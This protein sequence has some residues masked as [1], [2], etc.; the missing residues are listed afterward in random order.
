[1]QQANKRKHANMGQTDKQPTKHMQCVANHSTHQYSCRRIHTNL[2]FRRILIEYGYWLLELF[3][4]GLF[5][6]LAKYIYLLVLFNEGENSFSVARFNLSPALQITRVFNNLETTSWCDKC[7]FSSLYLRRCFHSF[8]SVKDAG[9]VVVVLHIPIIPAIG[10]SPL[11]NVSTFAWLCSHENG[12]GVIF[13]IRSS[14]FSIFTLHF[15]QP[16]ARLA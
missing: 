14:P 1:M 7:V 8:K 2:L 6:C 16:A 12:L 15:L 11:R 5:F 10:T 4:I 9:W 13:A 3:D